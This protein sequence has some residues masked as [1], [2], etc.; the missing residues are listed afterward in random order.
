MTHNGWQRACKE[1]HSGSLSPP[2]TRN[3][4]TFPTKSVAILK[5]L[6][7]FCKQPF[8]QPPS[9]IT[10]AKA[11]DVDRLVIRFTKGS[12]PRADHRNPATQPVS[13]AFMAT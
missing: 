9:P 4:R 8:T 12:R 13:H 11:N 3:F 6:A 1:R 10:L 7:I 5:K 2:K